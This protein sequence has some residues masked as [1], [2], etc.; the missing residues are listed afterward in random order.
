MTI[1]VARGVRGHA[2][3]GRLLPGQAFGIYGKRGG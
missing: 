2:D 1:H 3:S